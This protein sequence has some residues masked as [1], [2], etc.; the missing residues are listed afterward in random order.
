M[1]NEDYNSLDEICDI[2]FDVGVPGVVASIPDDIKAKLKAF[3]AR[4]NR[5]AVEKKV[6][7]WI[8]EQDAFSMQLFYAGLFYQLFMEE[9]NATKATMRLRGFSRKGKHLGDLTIIGKL[10]VDD[11]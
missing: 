3:V 8:R 10:E 9:T 2:Q 4:E 5:K 11:E 6:L 1:S 7:T